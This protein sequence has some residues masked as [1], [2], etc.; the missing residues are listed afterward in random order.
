MAD[1]LGLNIKLH[2]LNPEDAKLQTHIYAPKS[3]LVFNHTIEI[4]FEMDMNRRYLLY[5]KEDVGRIASNIFTQKHFEKNKNSRTILEQMPKKFQ[6][7]LL[8]KNSNWEEITRTAEK[9]L[10]DQK[11]IQGKEKE[12]ICKLL[13]GTLLVLQTS[14]DTIQQIIDTTHINPEKFDGELLQVV[15]EQ[16]VAPLDSNQPFTMNFKDHLFNIKRM[17][18][19]LQMP[20]TKAKLQNLGRVEIPHMSGPPTNPFP[21]KKSTSKF[22]L[23][24]IY[25][26]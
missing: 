15:L 10:S 21:F 6:M 12:N 1:I 2:E 11:I 24:V 8:E 17:I 25:S 20:E 5:R 7:Y 3:G 16:V 4:L 14:L 13:S 23:Y 22:I 18:S 26:L 19:D 9:E